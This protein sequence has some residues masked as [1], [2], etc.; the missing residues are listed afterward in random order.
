[1]R[2]EWDADG[3]D[4]VA[5]L[6]G[7]RQ[8]LS[9][10][11]KVV[12]AKWFR[13]RAT[14]FSQEVFTA[15]LA[16]MGTARAPRPRGEAGQLLEILESDSPLSTKALRQASG[17]T[18]KA[19]ES[20]YTKALKQLWDRLWITGF[21]EVDDGAFPSLAI[22]ATRSMHEELWQAASE[23]SEDEARATWERYAPPGSPWHKVYLRIL[24]AGPGAGSSINF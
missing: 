11:G 22:G 1:M 17:L 8:E 19:L 23:L 18:G 15:L 7:H 6:W 14:F 21:G 16:L 13:G 4:R 20:A 24:A 12:Y 5:W 2:W 3:D 9:A 10:S